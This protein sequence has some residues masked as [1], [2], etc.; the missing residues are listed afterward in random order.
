MI[1]IEF[2]R[3][4]SAED[5][6]DWRDIYKEDLEFSKS[7][8]L[9]YAERKAL[10]DSDFAIVLKVK[11]KRGKGYR[12]IRMFPI[13][14]ESHVRNALARLGQ[15]K[16]QATLKKLGISKEKVLKKILR[17]AKEL[18]MTQLLERYEK[19]QSAFLSEE[20][21]IEKVEQLQKELEQYKSSIETL[22]KEKAELE[23]NNQNLVQEKEKLEKE[24][25]KLETEV[26]KEQ[27][28]A[29]LYKKQ[30]ELIAKRRAELGDFAKDLS[31]ED[32]LDDTKYELARLRK[33]NYELRQK[34]GD[35]N[36]GASDEGDE[37]NEIRKK[38]WEQKKY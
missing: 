28:R 37:I 3:E 22:E 1:T 7:K 2:V 20:E 9:T 23:K 33:E 35:M 31:D 16:V 12:K 24:K 19:K 21:L 5:V 25:E 34:S 30:G 4:L 13:H 27:E 6:K 11:K 29:E 32:L 8:K 38:V 17:R 36:T 18:G 15:K 10:P 14:D 26:K